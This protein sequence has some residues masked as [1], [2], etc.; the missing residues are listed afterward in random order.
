MKKLLI[1][2]GSRYIIPAIKAAH[3]LGVYVISCDYLPDNIGH[4]YSDEYHN[5]S[6]IEKEKVLE[7]A[8][9]LHVDGILSFATDPG[10][11]AAAYAAEKLGLPTSPYESVHIL[12]NKNLFRAFLKEHGFNVP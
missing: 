7:L 8:G 11:E 4:H 9:R 3:Q 1:L 2:G 10:V 12:Q 6:I 5:I